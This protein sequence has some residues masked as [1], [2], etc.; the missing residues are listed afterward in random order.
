MEFE[1]IYKESVRVLEK[2]ECDYAVCG[3][4][5][6]M[7]YRSEPRF[8]ADID[9]LVSGPKSLVEFAT[10]TIESF[11][12]QANVLRMAELA[13]SPTMHKKTSPIAVIVGRDATDKNA[14]GLDF[15]MPVQGW[16]KNALERAKDNIISLHDVK[17]PFLTAEDLLLSK[18][19]AL[20]GAGRRREKDW[21]DILSIVQSGRK[22]DMAY[23][24][25]EIDNLKLS[26]PL[27][28]ER[29][30]PKALAVTFKRIRTSS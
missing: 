21:S 8:T 5:A 10:K 12:L 11:G 18:F 20:T 25:G 24:S 26:I 14:P 19:T 2:K 29:E 6:A 17:A 28:L 22:L 4:V 23:L 15:L 9:F 27:E 7:L 30:L 1:R 13:R 3:G 16:T